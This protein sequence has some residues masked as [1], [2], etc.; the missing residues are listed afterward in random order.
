M[1]IP[2]NIKDINKLFN[3]DNKTKIIGL[4]TILILLWSVLYFIPEVFASLFN[5]LL[6]N[7]ILLTTVLLV[8]MYNRPYGILLGIIFIIISRSISL[9][10]KEKEGFYWTTKS[11]QDFLKIQDTINPKIIFD[12][13]LIQ[14]NQAN[15]DELNYFNQNG[16]WPWTETT[17]NLY[18]N[19]VQRNPFIRTYSG[20]SVNYARKIYNESAILR[21]L[22]YQ[23]KEGQLLLNG[24]KISDPSGNPYED[25]PSGFGAFG[26]TS[27]LVKN[28]SDDV[29][30]CNSSSNNSTL[31]RITYTG[32]GGIFGEQTKKITPVDYNNLENIIPGFKFVNGPCNPCGNIDENPNYTCPFELKTKNQP[33]GISSVWNHLWRLNN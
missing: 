31:E 32:K 18:T 16:M 7:L 29:I 30:K 15:Q 24:A 17:I 26:F 28:L 13:N 8:T 21:I 20:D 25:L 22:S 27:G 9:S 6:G 19:A 1:K 5:T 11:T 10:K 3:E 4:L 14:E 12:V 2:K 33:Q 23:T